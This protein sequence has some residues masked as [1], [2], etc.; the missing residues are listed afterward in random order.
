MKF[1][2]I[3]ILL[4]ITS[5]TSCEYD[6]QMPDMW[7][8]PKYKVQ[9]NINTID[10]VE[11]K[12]YDIASVQKIITFYNSS[13]EV[14]DEFTYNSSQDIFVIPR[15][16]SYFIARIS[17]YGWPSGPVHNKDELVC[18]LTTNPV[19]VNQNIHPMDNEKVITE[20]FT[21]EDVD[22][23]VYYTPQIYLLYLGTHLQSQLEEWAKDYGYELWG[24]NGYYTIFDSDNNIVKQKEKNNP[25]DGISCREGWYIQFEVEAL[26]RYSYGNIRPLFTV[27]FDKVP[28]EEIAKHKPSKGNPYLFTVE[29]EYTLIYL[30]NKR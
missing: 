17:C 14:V 12:G 10:L 2:K 11:T 22:N 15:D 24:S 25:L 16:V 30:V 19:K 7:V 20:T 13:N 1:L 4:L 9:F 21:M 6:Y 18:E 28:V 8:I 5:L 26:Y 3:F 27:L 29:N 23:I